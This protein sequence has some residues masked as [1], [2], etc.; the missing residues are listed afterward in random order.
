MVSH[1]KLVLLLGIA[2][3]CI[4]FSHALTPAEQADMVA[5]H[6]NWRNAVGVPQMQWS[7]GLAVTAQGWANT[8]QQNQGCKMS[9]SGTRGLGENVYWASPVSYSN[10]TRRLQTVT[11]TRVTDAWGSEQQYYDYATNTCAR[12]Q[13]CGHFTQ[14]VWK[15]TTAVG[16]AKAVCGDLSQV[17]VCNYTPPG[18]WR[19]QRPY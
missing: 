4:N 11:A 13:V 16:C 10:G 7:D 8:L 18:N 1:R 19:G 5:A 14:I 3:L 2:T 12:G 6:N 17:W 15:T 9:H